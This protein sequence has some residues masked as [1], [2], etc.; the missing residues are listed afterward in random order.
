MDAANRYSMRSAAGGGA[1]NRWLAGWLWLRALGRVLWL[2]RFSVATVAIGAYALLVNE[3]TQEVL[4]EFA[5]SDGLASD[6]FELVAFALAN[7]LWC[8]NSWSWS[9]TLTS[10]RY[11]EVA[12]P[13][14]PEIALRV[15]VPRVL[16]WLPAFIVPIALLRSAAAFAS[17]PLPTPVRIYWL[18]GAF[19][20]GATAFVA[21]TLARRRLL[22]GDAVEVAASAPYT[23]RTLPRFDR[24]SV[25]ATSI[26]TVAM[27]LLFLVAPSRTAPWFGAAAILLAALAAW[28]PFGSVLVAG[29]RYLHDVPLFVLLLLLAALFSYWND[30]HEVRVLA[31]MRGAAADEGVRCRDDGAVAGQPSRYPLCDYALRWIESRRGEIA[32]GSGPYPVYL[33]AAAGGGIR[34]AYWTGG[35]LASLQD[36]DPD[37]AR[38]TFA[39]SAVSGGSFGA[40]TFVGLATGDAACRARTGGVPDAWPLAAHA[41]VI[42]AGDFLAPALGAMLYPDLVQ[43]FFPVAVP[44]ADRA[45]AFEERW[46]ERWREM[47]DDDW[48]AQSY[49]SLSPPAPQCDRPLLL[50]N[51]TTVAGGKR[52]LVAPLPVTPLEFPDT[53]D[54]RGIVGKPLRKSTAAHLSARFMYVS[55][56]ATVPAAPRGGTWG[57]LVDGGY[58]E[59]SGAATLADVL[60]L[61]DRAAVNA[62]LADRIVPVAL[63]LGNDPHAP[64]VED[65]PRRSPPPPVEP[66]PLAVLAEPRV[67]I[68][69]LLNAREGR[70]TQAQAAIKRAVEWRGGGRPPGHVEFY[71]P[72]DNGIPLPLGWMLSASAMSDLDAQIASQVETRSKP[73]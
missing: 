6:A 63:L 72:F 53:I 39:I 35:V 56:A 10:L 37:F 69:A 44:R 4:R 2:A 52:A 20:A 34:A 50:L 47:R 64:R 60:T 15:W 28:I 48:L 31:E 19:F 65:D 61:F 42:L 32:A 17:S 1:T 70:G 49:D 66:P 29:S 3:Q 12:P 71:Q 58:F 24:E 67:P 7:L 40:M 16:G 59:N 9:R 5:S 8:W 68:E 51:T 41:S 18:A 57:Y 13:G 11:P 38:H 62:G 21:W 25:I 46:E 22:G 27:F 14:P 33:V 23:M 36:R 55:P 43:R 26:V 54:V 45:R 30:N 73:R